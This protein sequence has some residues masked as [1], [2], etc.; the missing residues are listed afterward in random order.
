MKNIIQIK[1]DT[2]KCL[3]CGSCW[4]MN[5]VFAEQDDGKSS[6]TN[7]GIASQDEYETNIRDIIENCPAQAIMFRRLSLVQGE[8]TVTNIAKCIQ[9]TLVD[10]KFTKP[11]YWDYRF[12]GFS[13]P[14]ID[15]NGFY[16]YTSYDYSSSEKAQRAGLREMERVVFDNMNTIAK[17]LLI[18]YKHEKLR[19]FLNFEKEDGNYYYDE[20]AKVE[21]WILGI[22]KE[23]ENLGFHV[24]EELYK[25]NSVPDLGYNGKK[26]DE[27]YHIEEYMYTR[28]QE[29]INSPS[30]YE[31]DIDWDDYAV[32]NSKGKYSKT[33]Y[34]YCC[35][36]ALRE[37]KADLNSGAKDELS[38]WFKEVFAG[39]EFQ[40]VVEPIEKE[41]HEKGL[42][43]LVLLGTPEKHEAG[44]NTLDMIDPFGNFAIQCF[45]MESNSGTNQLYSCNITEENSYNGEWYNV[46]M[47]EIWSNDYMNRK[48]IEKT[49]NI[50]GFKHVSKTDVIY[51]VRSKG[52]S[53]RDYWL[54]LR[55]GEK[56]DITEFTK[57]AQDS[58]S[59][60]IVNDKMAVYVYNGMFYIYDLNLRLIISG[61]APRTKKKLFL[62]AYF[63]N[64]DDI[65]YLILNESSVVGVDENSVFK[66]NLRK[67]I[68]EKILNNEGTFCVYHN[69]LY[70]STKNRSVGKTDSYSVM[71]LNLSTGDVQEL[72]RIQYEQRYASLMSGDKLEIDGDT[73]VYENWLLKE[74]TYRIKI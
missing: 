53:D 27:I 2:E 10:Y 67:K 73:I 23:L 47:I 40:Q 46:P 44:V 1:I 35:H 70:Y 45:E 12:T 55:T 16:C 66:I 13:F 4:C 33:K 39:Y 69:S 20:I 18:E 59:V 71:K 60:S 29:D 7:Y 54:N 63:Y 3:G 43:L 62:T 48:M 21:A 24:D 68:T 64:I 14:N 17:R 65:F 36:G 28:I 57:C 52:E 30:Y 56:K 74:R 25:I 42:Q 19:T 5:S 61:N 9:G 26:F 38:D 32:Y 15:G 41:I 51:R 72:K 37:V 49:K 34:A 31:T 50:A 11:E 8:T 22:C 58:S 6:V